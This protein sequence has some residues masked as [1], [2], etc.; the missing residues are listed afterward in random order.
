MSRSATVSPRR[1]D[2]RAL[3]TLYRAQN[4][5]LYPLVLLVLCVVMPLFAWLDYYLVGA[6]S[7][8]VLR[9]LFV[10]VDLGLAAFYFTLLI[11]YFLRP[12]IVRRYV[13]YFFLAAGH[14]ILLIQLYLMSMVGAVAE[15]Y[16]MALLIFGQSILIHLKPR[17][18]LLNL[19]VI[20]VYC[21]P[22]MTVKWPLALPLAFLPPLLAVLGLS[23]T[24]VIYRNILLRQHVDIHRKNRILTRSLGQVKELKRR[25][26]GDYFLTS[27]LIKPLGGNH[28]NSP[29]V[30][31]DIL[32][33]QKKAFRFRKWN[34]EIGGDLSTA[35]RIRLQNRNYVA[36]LN[37]DAMGKS[38]QGA[39][40]A[41]VLG[42]IFKSIVSRFEVAIGA[43]DRSPESWLADCF[44]QL[45]DVFSAFDGSMMA[46]AICGLLEEQQGI[47]YFVNAEHPR[48]VLSRHGRVRYLLER[49]F[50]SQKFGML[51]GPGPFQI[52]V[53][54]L[55]PEDILVMGS[56]GRQDIYLRDSQEDIVNEDADLFLEFVREGQGRP[57]E[58]LKRLLAAG[59]LADDISLMSLTY[60]P[61]EVQV[62][63][64]M[65]PPGYIHLK[66]KGKQLMAQAEWTD[67]IDAFEKALAF[68][69]DD[70]EIYPY[71][72][73]IYRRLR[74][75]QEASRM[76]ETLAW[77]TP[78]DTHCLYVASFG[79]RASYILDGMAPLGKG[80]DFGERFRLRDRK[81]IPNLLNLA[82]LYRL[83][84]QL[85]KAQELLTEVRTLEPE[86]A[87]ARRLDEGLFYS[88]KLRY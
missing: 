50:V 54:Q 59:R 27:L 5:R 57:D 51:S 63:Q 10:R 78:A 65:P 55:R 68:K 60:E 42:T 82:E 18:G 80:I 69:D 36:F 25:Q 45:H 86:N 41:L 64:F 38:I 22:L 16:I 46:T 1:V 6:R 85:E 12:I 83:N 58:I 70:P 52:N 21:V 47:L 79:V 43:R 33:R 23:V 39:G 73:S 66:Q 48:P 3:R 17:A 67:A 35:Y 24:T 20:A 62:A 30:S 40:G 34:V 31:V 7:G 77:L 2:D 49:E 11:L 9:D 56:D 44:Y 13:L 75:T 15:P 76:Y 26:D 87:R 72:A 4:Q 81:H 32:T 29:R 61:E 84:G 71:M 53:I 88:G 8:K 74:R 14:T 19:A 28:V 37:G